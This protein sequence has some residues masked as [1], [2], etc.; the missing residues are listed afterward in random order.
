MILPSL[1][2]YAKILWKKYSLFYLLAHCSS[3][4]CVYRYLIFIFIY[5][6]IVYHNDRTNLKI[7]FQCL[8]VNKNAFEQ[9][10]ESYQI[11]FPNILI[12]SS[13]LVFLSIVKSCHIEKKTCRKSMKK[14]I[15]EMFSLFYVRKNMPWFAWC[16][17]QKHSPSFSYI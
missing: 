3:V 13:W 5:F 7:Q 17:Q 1:T 10:D 11:K 9:R 4:A 6:S 15:F 8:Q 2:K 16:M 12:L 14:F